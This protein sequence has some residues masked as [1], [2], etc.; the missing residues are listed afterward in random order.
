MISI[1][2]IRISKG[3]LSM[4][5]T[6]EK[7]SRQKPDTYVVFATE[8]GKLTGPAQEMDK[9]TQGAL[10]R[11]IAAEGFQGKKGKPLTIIAPPGLNAGH[12]VIVG[13]GTLVDLKARDLE[14][15][16]SSLTGELNARKATA[17]QI[18]FGNE[19]KHVPESEAASH[20]ASG[21]LL[22]SY[23]F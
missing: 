8:G 19:L 20:L 21:L 22:S 10:K 16:G 23:R 1:Y 2:I 6:F 18:I 14:K 15:I 4:K 5:I 9:K 17:A 3:K 12:V 7:K 13:L 11:A